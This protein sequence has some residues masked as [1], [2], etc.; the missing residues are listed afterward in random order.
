MTTNST[1]ENSPTTTTP[2]SIHNHSSCSS[3]AA[4][5]NRLS[6]SPTTVIY[7]ER[8]NNSLPVKLNDPN[9]PHHRHHQ[10]QL[11]QGGCTSSAIPSLS[12][13]VNEDARSCDTTTHPHEKY[14]HHLDKEISTSS[15]H[16]DLDHHQQRQHLNFQ[17]RIRNVYTKYSQSLLLENTASVAR[18]HLGMFILYNYQ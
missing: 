4:N 18:D 2:S 13:T 10:H 5:N 8:R 16:Q 17:Y 14:H 6:W 9:Y 1:K 15:E 12:P 3:I 11:L 7:D